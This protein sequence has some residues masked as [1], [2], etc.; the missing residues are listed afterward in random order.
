MYLASDMKVDWQ[1]YVSQNL[2]P[3]PHI[4]AKRITQ[5]RMNLDLVNNFNSKKGI[6]TTFSL[7]FPWNMK[8]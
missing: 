3:N 6:A 8:I 5:W 2:K 1:P 4:Q 7:N